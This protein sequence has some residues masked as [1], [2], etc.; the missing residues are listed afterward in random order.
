MRKIKCILFH[1]L[2]LIVLMSCQTSSKSDDQTIR[3][4][5]EEERQ[6]VLSELDRTTSELRT[7]IEDLS[8]DQWNFREQP[9]RWNIGEIV[10]HLEMQNQLHFR[11]ISVIAN[12][13]Q[14]L[15]YRKIVQ[16]GDEYFTKYATDTIKGQANWFLQ[17]KGKFATKEATESAFYLAR[18]KLRE[19]VEATQ[20]DLRKQFTFRSPMYE[21]NLSELT[22]RDVR[23]LHQLLL[24]GIAHTD[25][26]LRQIRNI[27]LHEEYPVN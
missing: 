21:K 11:E 27:K 15:E 16:D 1:S 2:L 26:H 24:T 10:E 13:P 8:E 22:I 18:G 12:S 4:W 19:Y 6:L 5:S 20:A 23:D 7:E 14:Y 17:P 9:V 3:W 25:R